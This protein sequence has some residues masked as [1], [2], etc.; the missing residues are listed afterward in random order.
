LESP[1]LIHIDPDS[2][3]GELIIEVSESLPP[4]VDA[5]VVEPV[6][7]DCNLRP[8]LINKVVI[9]LDRLVEP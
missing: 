4:H 7:K 8:Y 2:V 6:N 9:V 1:G 5:L 3:I